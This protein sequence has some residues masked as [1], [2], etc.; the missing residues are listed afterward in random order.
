MACWIWWDEISTVLQSSKLKCMHGFDDLDITSY[1]Q[2]SLCTPN[3]QVFMQMVVSRGNRL[4]R[5]W[6]IWTAHSTMLNHLDCPAECKTSF[7]AFHIHWWLLHVL[8]S[9]ED[10]GCCVSPQG[11]YPVFIPRSQPLCRTCCIKT[12]RVFKVLQIW[13]TCHS[14][15]HQ[16]TREHRQCPED[17]SSEGPLCAQH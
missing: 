8:W 15:L 14:F 4:G 3:I 9:D 6:V 11:W 5:E 16:E 7:T 2:L 1:W 10:S 12:L 13:L 17:Q